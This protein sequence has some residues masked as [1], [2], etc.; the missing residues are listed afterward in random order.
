MKRIS[1]RYCNI[2]SQC[3]KKI[4]IPQLGNPVSNYWRN[5]RLTIWAQVRLI[6]STLTKTKSWCTVIMK[7]ESCT[8]QSATASGHLTCL[9]SMNLPTKSTTSMRLRMSM[10]SKLSLFYLMDKKL[11][12]AYRANSLINSFVEVVTSLSRLMMGWAITN[13]FCGCRQSK[14]F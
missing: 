14:K 6:V 9:P 13:G 8:S 3:P 5:L 2:K 10:S 1:S 12:S 11:S 7:S 4:L